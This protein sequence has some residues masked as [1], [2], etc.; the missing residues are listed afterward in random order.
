MSEH[1]Q[2]LELYLK[3]QQD[4]I[5]E[6]SQQIMILNTRNKLLEQQLKEAESISAEKSKKIEEYEI[7]NNKKKNQVKGFSH[8]Q[9]VIGR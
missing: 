5:N 1:E 4:K 7:I 9:T 6:L 2:V 3:E 8:K